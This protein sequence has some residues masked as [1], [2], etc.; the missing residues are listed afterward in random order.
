[1]DRYE[2]L[3]QSAEEIFQYTNIDLSNENANTNGRSPVGMLSLIASESSKHYAEGLL[4][5]DVLEAYNDGFMHI[6]DFDFYATGTTTCCQIPVGKLLTNG[7]YVG[8][9][10]MRPPQSIG[11]ALALTAIILQSN[12]N[13]QHGGQAV[14]NFDF[15]LA[16]FVSVSYHKH[17]EQILDTCEMIGTEV[18]YEEVRRLAWKRTYEETMQACEG[19]VHNANSMLCRNGCQV[20][21]I[22]INFGLDTSP[23]GRMVSECIMK[24]QQK[25]MGDGA[26]PIF[27][28]L[29]FKC[30]KDINLKAGTPNH[31]LY[32]LAIETTSKRLFP[33][34]VNCDAPFNYN[35]TG[36]LR[37]EIATM[38][39]NVK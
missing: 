4:D 23:E 35:P 9:C 27:P 18:D 14:P 6:H 31:D 26:T 11:T 33:N 36:D 16:P 7:F 2:Q 38:G 10:F 25:G 20:P 17:K 21:F 29:V 34:F 22:S 32:M 19:F 3:M 28:I 13:N 37:K 24:A 30:K 39:K 5:K 8:E 1:M 15:D 12:Q